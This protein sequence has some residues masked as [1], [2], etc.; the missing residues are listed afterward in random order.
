MSRRQ[1][2]ADRR[3]ELLSQ[4]AA[5]AQGDGLAAVTAEHLGRAA[6]TSKALVFHYFGSVRGLRLAVLE[7][8][9]AAMLAATTTPPGLD[10]VERRRMLLSAFLDRVRLR[11]GI[12]L[13]VWRGPLAGDDGAR[14]LLEVARLQ[15]VDRV[16]A[17]ATGAGRPDGPGFTLLARG[18]VALVEEVAADWVSGVQVSRD[19][20]TALLLTSLAVLLPERPAAPGAQLPRPA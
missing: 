13:G 14:A 5:I 7:D 17:V 2:P 19:E 12:W 18:W 16:V 6:G 15:I 4:A 1:E 3:R 11:R 8:E 10:T 20:V 9:V